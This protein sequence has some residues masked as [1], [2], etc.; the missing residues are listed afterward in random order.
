MFVTI[1]IENYEIK[2]ESK[3]LELKKNNIEMIHIPL[4]S[5]FEIK[6]F[7]KGI[8]FETMIVLKDNAGTIYIPNNLDNHEKLLSDVYFHIKGKKFDFEGNN[9]HQ[10]DFVNDSTEVSS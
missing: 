2:T 1:F 9:I 3:A 8:N 7:S 10:Y 4:E 6:T 5:I